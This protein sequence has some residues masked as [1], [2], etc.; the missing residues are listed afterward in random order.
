L[1]IE[2]FSSQERKAINPEY[3]RRTTKQ[4]AVYQ[5]ERRRD[6]PAYKAAYYAR[7][8]AWKARRLI[9]DPDYVN[10]QAR[11][12]LARKKADDPTFRP[13]GKRNR[14]EA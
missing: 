8:R 2:H 11:E 14:T 9:E 4:Q 12:Y 13:R 10:R 3:A 7:Q 5:R 1:A 6:D